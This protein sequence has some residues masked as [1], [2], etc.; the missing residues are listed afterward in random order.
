M[1]GREAWYP[2]CSDATQMPV[3]NGMHR[4]LR[5]IVM[6]PC[7]PPSPPCAAHHGCQS[8]T[9]ADTCHP[10]QRSRLTIKWDQNF[11]TKIKMRLVEKIGK[12]TWA[13]AYCKCLSPTHPEIVQ[14]V[15]C[16]TVGTV[17]KPSRIHGPVMM[18]VEGDLQINLRPPWDTAS[19]PSTEVQLSHVPLHGAPQLLRCECE[20]HKGPQPPPCTSGTPTHTLC[21]G[22]TCGLAGLGAEG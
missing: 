3:E 11:R 10:H 13:I 21:C 15:T 4:T 19:F 7:S 14:C 2:G 17:Q 6:A 22:G 18:A 12:R 16:P 1:G 9:I 5:G 20:P 8:L